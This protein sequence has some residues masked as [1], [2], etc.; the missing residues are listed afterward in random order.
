MGKLVLAGAM[1]LAGA[2]SAS[3][4]QMTLS[5]PDIKRGRE[6]QDE[7]SRRF[8]LLG[9]EYIAGAKLVRSA[10]GDEEL[11]AQHPRS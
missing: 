11:R 1:L 8:W 9:Q 5:S 7:R 10:E 6:L 3:A 2:A 4:A